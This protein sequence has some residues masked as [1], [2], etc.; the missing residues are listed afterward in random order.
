MS[1]SPYLTMGDPTIN[2]SNIPMQNN[3]IQPPRTQSVSVEPSNGIQSQHLHAM[4][5]TTAPVALAATAPAEK[6]LKPKPQGAPKSG[7]SISS[8]D[9]DLDI[10]DDPPEVRPAIIT[11]AKPET[12]KEKLLWEVVDAVW[13]PRNK[14]AS[15]EKIVSAI[16]SVGEAVRGLREQ[17]KSQNEKLKKAELPNSEASGHAP[18]LKQLVGHLREI[19]ESL[20]ARVTKWGHPSILKRYV[21]SS[22]P[23]PSCCCCVC[24]FDL[25]LL[26]S[27][28]PSFKL[29]AAAAALA[30]IMVITYWALYA[31][32]WQPRSAKVNAVLDS[33]KYHPILS[34][35][36]S[37][38]LEHKLILLD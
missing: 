20:A 31:C 26:S 8:S 33:L 11:V 37:P 16:K 7:G 14:P 21:L 24:T 4:I 6:V 32:P 25:S 5:P 17:W 3:Q 12:Y 38:F 29:A 18:Q 35:V 9:D 27:L 15:S 23:H 36:I 13:T 28:P 10:E 2:P 22:H 1:N 34:C 19:M 30:F